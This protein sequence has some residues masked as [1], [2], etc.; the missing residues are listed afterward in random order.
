MDTHTAVA[1]TSCLKVRYDIQ[2]PSRWHSF[3]LPRR[4]EAKQVPAA[5]CWSRQRE[6]PCCQ[7]WLV[8]EILQLRSAS[9]QSILVVTLMKGF[10]VLSLTLHAW[11]KAPSGVTWISDPWGRALEV[12]TLA[13]KLKVWGLYSLG[14]L[15]SFFTQMMIVWS[16]MI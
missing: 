11:S 13:Y 7:R 15:S 4:L 12:E 6:L 1:C 14:F 9:P 5:K 10:F 3:L 8:F 16:L 2:I